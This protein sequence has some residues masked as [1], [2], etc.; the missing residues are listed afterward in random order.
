MTEQTEKYLPFNAINEFMRDDYRL[1]VLHE[2]FGHLE[3]NPAE[4]RKD[5]SQFVTRYIK[6][7]GFRNSNAAPAGLKAKNSP[8]LFQQSADFTAVIL[9]AWASLHPDLKQSVWQVISERGWEPLP[10]EADR[11]QLPGFQ[12]HWPKADTFESFHTA[13]KERMPDMKESEDDISL[14][15][16]WMGNR[17][18][19]DLFIEETEEK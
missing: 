4:K 10:V 8:A 14:M 7:P 5:I 11:S 12:I 18:P 15:V 3:S 13:L 9:E 19:Y 6:I 17:L 2:V 1:T 16:V